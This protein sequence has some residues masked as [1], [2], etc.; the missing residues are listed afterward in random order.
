MD[1]QSNYLTMIPC[2]L[3]RLDIPHYHQVY[4][5]SHQKHIFLMRPT[6]HILSP[7]DN[8]VTTIVSP[9]LIIMTII[10]LPFGIRMI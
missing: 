8:Y 5:N 1:P 7:W 4:L 10:A 2:M 6:A 3:P 9:F